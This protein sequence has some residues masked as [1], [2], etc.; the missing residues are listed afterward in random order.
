MAKVT[1]HGTLAKKVLNVSFR[2]SNVANLTFSEGEEVQSLGE[3]K[4][5]SEA[6]LCRLQ[7]REEILAK[8]LWLVPG[9][10]VL[11]PGADQNAAGPVPL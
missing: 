9:W 6:D 11:P 3:T 2:F 10:T 7:Q 5:A 1:K 8:I 4:A